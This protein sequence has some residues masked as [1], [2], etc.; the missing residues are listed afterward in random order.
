MI[1]GDSKITFYTKD[2]SITLNDVDI[3]HTNIEPAEES[4]YVNLNITGECK[5]FSIPANH[6]GFAMLMM[7]FE[8]FDMKTAEQRVTFMEMR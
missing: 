3:K 2:K 7:M 8:G 1:Y 4:G 5:S 6:K